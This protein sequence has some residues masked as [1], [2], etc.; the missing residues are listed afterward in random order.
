MCNLFIQY[1]FLYVSCCVLQLLVNINDL[2]KEC[3]YLILYNVVIY[4]L[5]IACTVKKKEKKLI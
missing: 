3:K 1:L 4:L 5:S 2:Y